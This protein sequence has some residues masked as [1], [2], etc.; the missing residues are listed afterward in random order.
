MKPRLQG[1]FLLC[2][3]SLLIL[4]CVDPQTRSKVEQRSQQ[5]EATLETLQEELRQ[6]EEKIQRLKAEIETAEAEFLKEQKEQSYVVLLPDE[7]TN[8]SPKLS[9]SLTKGILQKIWMQDSLGTEQ[10]QR[11]VKHLVEVVEA[12][13]NHVKNWLSQF[14]SEESFYTPDYFIR[15]VQFSGSSAAT[16]PLEEENSIDLYLL[17][18]PNQLDGQ[19]RSYTIRGLLNPHIQAWGQRKDFTFIPLRH[20]LKQVKTDTLWIG[21]KEFSFGRPAALH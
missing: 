13:E 12:K 1:F 10:G 14:V 4:A 9:P 21:Q 15:L 8:Y 2:S 18:Q 7:K 6:E 11:S 5:T 17:I 19:V 16:I 20:G 3:G